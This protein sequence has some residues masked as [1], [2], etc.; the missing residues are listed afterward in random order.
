MSAA[1]G[2]APDGSDAWLVYGIRPGSYNDES[3][4]EFLEADLGSAGTLS[5]NR[6]LR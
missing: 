3:L 1:V 6:E 2:Y 4:I 5:R